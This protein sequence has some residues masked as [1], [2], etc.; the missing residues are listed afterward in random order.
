MYANSIHRLYHYNLYMFPDPVG[1]DEYF[2]ADIM[3]TEVRKNRC[4][5]IHTS[6]SIFIMDCSYKD[7]LQDNGCNPNVLIRVYQFTLSLLLVCVFQNMFRS[8]EGIF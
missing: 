5:F 6:I 8:F 1:S 7:F 4:P 2:T 3:Y